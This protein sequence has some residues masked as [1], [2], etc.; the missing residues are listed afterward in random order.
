MESNFLPKSK[1]KQCPLVGTTIL[2]SKG[3]IFSLKAKKNNVRWW[4]QQFIW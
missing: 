2:D 1:G 3:R 4:G